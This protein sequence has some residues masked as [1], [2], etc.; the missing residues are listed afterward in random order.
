VKFE[1]KLCHLMGMGG[2][3][4]KPMLRNHFFPLPCARS[5]F[6]N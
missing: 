3:R 4:G 1:L 6:S 5:A 2:K